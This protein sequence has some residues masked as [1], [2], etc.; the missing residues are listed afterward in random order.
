MNRD[1]GAKDIDEMDDAGDE[2]LC[3]EPGEGARDG[4]R[5]RVDEEKVGLDRNSD[6]CDGYPGQS[7]VWYNEVVKGRGKSGKD[8]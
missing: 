1:E 7:L 2:L 3:Q 5:A 8:R 4:G 6:G